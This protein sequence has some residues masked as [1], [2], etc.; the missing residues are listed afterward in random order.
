MVVI[1]KGVDVHKALTV[2]S[3]YLLLGTII[4]T[5]RNI[6]LYKVL[7][8]RSISLRLNTDLLRF[9]WTLQSSH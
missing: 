1:I 7:S 4:F 3:S 8:L 6:W 5:H 9:S 2:G